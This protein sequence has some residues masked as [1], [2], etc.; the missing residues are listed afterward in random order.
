MTPAGSEGGHEDYDWTSIQIVIG[1]QTID[2]NPADFSGC[3]FGRC[4]IFNSL[5]FSHGD[6]TFHV[7]MANVYFIPIGSVI[8]LAADYIGGQTWWS[9]GVP[10][11][12]LP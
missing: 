7:D 5:D 2:T 1:E 8:H 9:G 3:V 10:P 12:P 6:G 4:G 11:F